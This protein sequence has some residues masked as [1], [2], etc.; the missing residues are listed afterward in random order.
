MI[1]EIDDAGTG[2]LVGDAFIGLLRKNNGQIVFKTLPLALFKG[3]NWTN[4]EPLEKVVELVKDG[5]KE[6]NYQKD[7]D[8]I[9]LCRGNIFDD[10]RNYFIKE[11]INYEDAIVEGKLQDAVEGRLVEH[12]RNDLGVR[13]SQLTKKSGA[14]RFFVLFNWVCYDFYKREKFVKSGFK[15][16]NIIWRDRAIEKYNKLKNSR[17]RKTL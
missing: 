15:K 17:K 4:K 8:V 12:L 11:G 3:E 6:L 16:W 13:S 10:L 14:K 9:H 5:L 1:I 2:D 7:T